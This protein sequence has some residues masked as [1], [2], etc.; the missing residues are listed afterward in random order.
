MFSEKRYIKDINSKGIFDNTYETKM[1]QTIVYKAILNH[2]ENSHKKP[3]CLFLGWDGCR[4]DAMKYLIGADNMCGYYSA[5]SK[6]KNTGGLYVTYVGGDKDYEQETSTA[7]GWASA[8]CGKWMKKEWREGIN[9]SLDESSPTIMK[10]LALKGYGT[11]FSAI[12]PI[13]FDN[14]YKNEICDAQNNN[15]NMY[16]CK[17]ETDE[18]LYTD[19][20]ERI[21]SDSDLIFGIFENPDMNGH[22]A[23]FGDSNYKYISGICNLDR[24]SYNLIS[25][26]KQRSTFNEEDWLVLIA[27]DHG[28]HSTR[29]GTQ[30]F[31]D[32]TTFLA[33]SKSAEDLNL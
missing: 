25:S 11:T 10:T 13:H 12:W 32:R 1:P 8:L 31:Q 19:I 9:W 29:H 30:S 23:G 5:V 14:T 6:V 7:Q 3:K 22:D 33:L 17:I 20:K 28:G 27:S 18:E 15:L 2:F 4:A 24:V 26:I 16:Y 21:Q